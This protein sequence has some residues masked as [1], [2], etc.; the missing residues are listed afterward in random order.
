MASQSQAIRT[1]VFPVAG[2]GTRFLPATTL[3]YTG[4]KLSS[5]TDSAGRTITITYSASDPDLIETVSLPAPDNRYVEYGYQ[6]GH[7]TSVRDARGKQAGERQFL[8]SH[9]GRL[10]FVEA[11][12][13]LVEGAAEP[14]DIVVTFIGATAGAGAN[15]LREQ[16]QLVDRRRRRRSARTTMRCAASSAALAVAWSRSASSATSPDPT[17]RCPSPSSSSTRAAR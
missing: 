8:V 1:A 5:I 13:H 9:L 15:L 12:E 4:G 17:V 3:A 2:R 6:N 16:H 7:L 11:I 14:P 10:R